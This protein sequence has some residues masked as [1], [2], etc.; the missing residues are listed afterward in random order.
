MYVFAELPDFLSED[1]CD[2]IIDLAEMFG[3]ESS[4]MHTDQFQ[5]EH[6][7]EVKGTLNCWNRLMRYPLLAMVKSNRLNLGNMTTIRPTARDMAKIIF[8]GTN[9]QP[10]F[11]TSE[12]E[13]I[14]LFFR[15]YMYIYIYIYVCSNQ[16]LV[17][18]KLYFYWLS[19]K[20]VDLEM[21]TWT[22]TQC[23]L[24]LPSAPHRNSPY[25]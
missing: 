24:P 21:K 17:S 11:N 12:C 2:H 7:N 4:I 19:K 1:E 9:Y 13:F 5:E 6:R 15:R 22:S 3:L 16:N 23:Y 25:T 14:F 10:Q 8:P 20:G 18:S